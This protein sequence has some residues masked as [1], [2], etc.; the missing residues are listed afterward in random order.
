MLA[1]SAITAALLV[2]PGL[3]AN[4]LTGLP[5]GEGGGGLV[6]GSIF[7]YVIGNIATVAAVAPG[8]VV[9]RITGRKSID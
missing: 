1:V 7:T 6:Y 4:L 2:V 5:D 9:R 3:V 8:R